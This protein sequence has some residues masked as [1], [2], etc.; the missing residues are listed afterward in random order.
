MSANMFASA[1]HAPGGPT[2]PVIRGEEMLR[3]EDLAVHFTTAPPG[4]MRRKME[5][6]RAVDG[7]SFALAA[8][9]MLD[10]DV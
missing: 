8:G 3:V 2:A 6:V 1:D 4:R 9:E 7:I 10:R 5:P